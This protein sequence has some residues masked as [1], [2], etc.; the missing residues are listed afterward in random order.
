MPICTQVWRVL[1][2]NAALETAVSELLSRD[3]K[4]ELA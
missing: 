3:M 4:V 2:G 1:N